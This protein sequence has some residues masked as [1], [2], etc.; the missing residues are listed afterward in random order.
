MLRGRPG[1]GAQLLQASA[2]G[3]AGGGAPPGNVDQNGKPRQE[4]P[5]GVS[6]RIAGVG[7]GSGGRRRGWLG[8]GRGLCLGG[9]L[10][11]G[12]LRRLAAGD[13]VGRHA[14]GATALDVDD[15][16][17]D[18]EV[19]V[20]IDGNELSLAEFGQPLK[21]YVGWGMRVTFVPRTPLRFNS[22]LRNRER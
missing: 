7:R 10:A 21:C 3:E 14:V 15:G 8:L 20:H 9:G 22:D 2:L 19:T 5:A 4:G 1:P 13:P 11:L 6:R 18:G 12:R 16:G 17:E